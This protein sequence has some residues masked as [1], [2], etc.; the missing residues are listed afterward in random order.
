MNMRLVAFL[1]PIAF[2]LVLLNAS[3]TR[4]MIPPAAAVLE[5]ERAVVAEQ[6]G[7]L[8]AEEPRST[9]QQPQQLL[10]E[11]ADAG[12]PVVVDPDAISTFSPSST[13]YGTFA[14]PQTAVLPSQAQSEVHDLAQRTAARAI[15]AGRDRAVVPMVAHD[16]VSK[17]ISTGKDQVMDR[18]ASRSSTIASP[19]SDDGIASPLLPADRA[20][21][22]SSDEIASPSPDELLP[23]AENDAGVSTPSSDG[24]EKES[25]GTEDE[26][27]GEESQRRHRRVYSARDTGPSTEEL[28]SL[29]R[30]QVTTELATLIDSNAG[31]Q[32]PNGVVHLADRSSPY[33]REDDYKDPFRH[34]DMDS[35]GRGGYHYQ[36]GIHKGRFDVSLSRPMRS[37]LTTCRRDSY[38]SANVLYSPRT[39]GRRHISGWFQ[40][41]PAAPWDNPRYARRRQ[42]VITYKIRGTASEGTRKSD[43][44]L[45]VRRLL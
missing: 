12:K 31:V 43:K 1:L 19:S 34:M 30:R 23:L 26:D 8:A 25:D 10:R 37:I 39:S 2:A 32:T 38:D 45:E 35:V 41:Q 18:I 29:G 27:T 24:E 13:R 9:S 40:L 33:F 42:R 3:T 16:F 17:T 14:L 21:L 6:A 22:L 28:I 36:G 44:L 4:A 11:K 15:S 7:E 20:A 5:E